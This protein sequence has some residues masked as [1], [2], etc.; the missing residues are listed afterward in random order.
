[1]LINYNVSSFIP[2]QDANVKHPL[3][4]GRYFTF[5]HEADTQVCTKEQYI[6]YRKIGRLFFAEIKC[7]IDQDKQVV[8]N[9][10]L[11]T[12]WMV[13]QLMGTSSVATATKSA[14]DTQQYHGF[15]R[16]NNDTP[17]VLKTGKVW[18]ILIGMQ[19]DNKAGFDQEWPTLASKID[20][21]FYL[22]PPLK[23]A[24]RNRKIL[25][26]IQRIKNV[27]FSL[28]YKLQNQVVQLMETY[29]GDLREHAKSIQP[30][31]ISLFHRAKDYIVAHYRDED[32]NINRIAQELL[33]SD[34]TLYRIFKENGLTINKAIQTI[35]IYKGREMLRETNA[36]VDM[37]AFH[38][39]FSTAKYFIKQYVKY[40]G[41]TPATERKLHP[42][43]AEPDDE[44]DDPHESN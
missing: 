36:S 9:N 27:P 6:A 34:R 32:I 38:L 18:L 3:P 29:H 11:P 10:T 31:D 4:R 13:F 2:N 5:L 37:I 23:I 1:M 15:F 44:D 7:V 43:P 17:Y 33:T 24:F 41:H 35:R 21:S 14:L 40:F 42:P 28:D 19:I 20:E 39:Q 8:L 30:E 22:L 16:E 12:F 26:S 25:E